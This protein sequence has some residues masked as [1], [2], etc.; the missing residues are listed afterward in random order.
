[1]NPSKQ[2]APA[3]LLSIAV[4][5]G[6]ARYGYGL[7]VPEFREDFG[8]STE[9]LGFIAAGAYASYLAALLATGALVARVG[10]RPLVVIGGLSAA[11][12][13][14]MIALAQNTILLVIGVILA[15]TSPGWAWAPF[16]D[17]VARMISPDIQSRTLSIITTGTTFGILVAGPAA[18]VAGGAWRGAWI[19]FAVVAIAVTVWDAFLLPSGPHQKD[20]EDDAA[21][22]P[23]LKPRWFIGSSSTRLFAVAASFGFGGT[24]YWTYAVDLIS[25]A[26]G[27]AE[28]AG[29]IFWA[30]VG[31]AGIAGVAT[32]DVMYR[33]GLRRSLV[34]ILLALG[35]ATLVLGAAPMSLL[36]LGMSSVLFGA[37]FMA[38][39]SLLVTWN[40]IVFPNQPGTGFSATQTF[41]ALGTISGPA[42]MGVFGG[43][44]GME[45]AFIVTGILV[46]LT[47]FV[48]PQEDVD[49]A[50]ND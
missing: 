3:G 9:A 50:E 31:A 47:V 41:L 20:D 12:G 10:P 26:G 30:V 11:G 18:L 48:K 21:E 34:G 2:L 22:Q 6:F 45:T 32:G 40:S 5:F 1:M 33:L 13:M 19:A 36:A 43:R 46:L 4:A 7:F 42:V 37:S 44:I 49:S 16:S 27:F 29:P 39:S 38:M 15:A 14:L 35:I 25:D 24:V 28:S 23:E 8:L 17:A